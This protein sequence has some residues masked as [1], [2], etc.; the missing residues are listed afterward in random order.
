MGVMGVL[1][2]GVGLSGMT[3]TWWA[4]FLFAGT[5]LLFATFVWLMAE[6]V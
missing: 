5:V 4:G 6:G 3:G 1:F 2:T